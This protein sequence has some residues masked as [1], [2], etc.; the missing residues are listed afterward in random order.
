VETHEKTSAEIRVHLLE[1]IVEWKERLPPDGTFM[2]T[3]GAGI[4]LSAVTLIGVLIK[5]AVDVLIPDAEPSDKP[6]IGF[7]VSTIERYGRDHKT[8]CV[9]PPRHLVTSPE[10][11]LLK[12][13]SRTRASLAH[14]E[15]EPAFDVS[16]IGRLGP[17]EVR[18]FLDLVG[19]V[20]RLAIFDELTCRETQRTGSK[21]T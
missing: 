8:I 17:S 11:K 2:G 20:A 4:A 12:R 9:Q 7:Y 14:Q 3:Y 19:T 18:D 16:M 5:R 21:A 10:V 6:T 1:K 15:G 13:L